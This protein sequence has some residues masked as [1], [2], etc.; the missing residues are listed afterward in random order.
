[1]T[2]DH[3]PSGAEN[4]AFRETVPFEGTDALPE[5]LPALDR[6]SSVQRYVILDR[7]GE[8]GMG[9]VYAAYDPSLDR[10]VALKFLGAHLSARDG[11]G[12]MR[13]LREAQAMARLSHPNVAVVYE[14]GTVDDR[15]FVAME[16]VD[17]VHLRAWLAAEPRSLSAILEL[18][19]AAGRGLAAAHAAGLVH[20]DFK[21]ENVLVDRHDRP[22]VT[23]FGISRNSP[24]V[25][26]DV[27]EPGAPRPANPLSTPAGSHSLTR[28]GGIL[29][30]PSYM[31]PEQ[32]LGDRADARADQFAFCV[33][34]YE[35]V[36]GVRPFAGSSPAQMLDAIVA[37]RV[38]PGSD[39]P[40]WL[41]AVVLRGLEP[42]PRDRWPS[43][44]ALIAA[45]GRQEG[46]GRRRWLLGG[47]LVAGLGLVAWFSLASPAEADPCPPASDRVAGIW[48]GPVR[49]KVR[50]AFL[51]TGAARAAAVFERVDRTLEHRLGSWVG[52]HREACR[53]TRVRGEQSEALLDLRMQCL[54][55]AR[56]QIAALPGLW[57]E[58]VSLDDAV[59]AALTVGE[60]EA[61]ENTDALTAAAPPPRDPEVRR[62]VEAL[63]RTL[64]RVA[65]LQR[66]GQVDV[67]LSLGREAVTEARRLGYAPLL[68]EALHRDGQMEIDLGERENGLALLHE[69]YHA[70]SEAHDD[71]RAATIMRLALYYSAL[72][73]KHFAEVD[74]L[75]KVAE[76]AVARVAN[77]DDLTADLLGT[78]GVV[79]S[80]QGKRVEAIER[81]RRALALKEKLH[82]AND[83]QVYAAAN[84]LAAVM[85]DSDSVEE[86]LALNQR[87]RTLLEQTLGPEHPQ[88]ATSLQNQAL[89][90]FQMGDYAGASRSA[91]RGLEMRR[92]I[93]P[94]D[95]PAIATGLRNLAIVRQAQY[96][97][98]EAT[99][100]LERAE[101]I[102]GGAPVPDPWT[103]AVIRED[104]AE[105]ALRRGD[106]PLAR[107]ILA[108]LH[109]DQGDN[110]DGEVG[111]S[112][113]R[114]ALELHDGKPAAARAAYQRALDISREHGEA[115]PLEVAA[116]LSGLGEVELFEGKTG[117]AIAS[118][119]RATQPIEKRPRGR[120]HPF[121]VPILTDLGRARLRAGQPGQAIQVLDRAIA[122]AD[123]DRSSARTP[124]G[125][126][127]FALAE[128][129]WTSGDRARAVALARTARDELGGRPDLARVDQ[130][131]QRHPAPGKGVVARARSVRP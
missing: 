100:L 68:A 126:A 67:G 83:F 108:D 53:A 79:L 102:A 49:E 44:D 73:S 107:R 115:D 97:D 62:K 87:V 19:R 123:A 85:L 58:K 110:G 29:G 48:A 89:I 80:Q 17:G 31:A 122:I 3:P 92:K 130:W 119:E 82:G 66:A 114:G 8:G 59:K 63:K 18:F 120:T 56:R 50:A 45:L 74:V 6:G 35:A 32:H 91:E 10:R 16:F 116:A 14:V 128:A 70:A 131:L 5:R 34:L 60:L 46:Q 23:D 75:W 113:T 21:P 117:A 22:R 47:G 61:C 42:D 11:I 36:A 52:A 101:R 118:F 84:N 25:V 109:R 104:L 88:V 13:L 124:A 41:R 90:L 55:R 57:Q 78:E 129:L 106:A 112:I 72:D 98:D 39:M 2:A 51:A 105:L 86:A 24:D 64:D 4:T 71:V 38:A 69:A 43:M 54:E 127:R 77:H 33:A 7:V 15:V 93:Y 20:R 121:L 26:G 96:R 1:M 37:R 28:T 103:L 94:A 9:V 99:E 111:R 65:A 12:E 40:R 30:T 76:A 27:P 81:L 95:H 125:R